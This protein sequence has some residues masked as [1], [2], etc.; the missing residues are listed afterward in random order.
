ML[1]VLLL[2]AIFY[3]YSKQ[4]NNLNFYFPLSYFLIC[5]YSPIHYSQL[6]T[7]INHSLLIFFTGFAIAAL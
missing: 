6:T 1:K 7:P 5:I 2:A 4:S 3:F